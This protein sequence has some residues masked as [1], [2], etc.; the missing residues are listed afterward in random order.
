MVQFGADE[1]LV[2]LSFV[3]TLFVLWELMGYSILFFY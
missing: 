2:R 3:G 1:L